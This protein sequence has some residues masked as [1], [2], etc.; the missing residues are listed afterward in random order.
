MSDRFALACAALNPDLAVQAVERMPAN[1][2]VEL[3]VVHGVPVSGRRRGL[4]MAVMVDQPPPHRRWRFFLFWLL[5]R[6]AA[7]C[8][9]FQFEIYRTPT[10]FD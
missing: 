5:L 1:S 8:Y 6:L 4:T 3:E 9:P 2:P 7:R 10:R